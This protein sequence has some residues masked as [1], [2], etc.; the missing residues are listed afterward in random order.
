MKNKSRLE[1]LQTREQLLEEVFENARGKLAGIQKEKGKYKELL[2]NLILQVRSVSLTVLELT[3]KICIK[4]PLHYHGAR[5][6]ARLPEGR[7]EGNQPA[8]GRCHQNLHRGSWL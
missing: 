7:P 5:S 2:K 6:L 1:L 8:Q 3:F 4:G